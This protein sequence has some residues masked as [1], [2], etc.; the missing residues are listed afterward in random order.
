MLSSFGVINP[1]VES[2]DDYN[3]QLY[4]QFK[5]L[6]DAELSDIDTTNTNWPKQVISDQISKLKKLLL[7][8]LSESYNQQSKI[9]NNDLL[10]LMYKF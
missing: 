4:I 7:L 10:K 9:Q 2:F 6:L 8:L 5:Y 3:N 1:S